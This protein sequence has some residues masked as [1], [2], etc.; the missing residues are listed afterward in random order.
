MRRRAPAAL[1]FLCLPALGAGI[2]APDQPEGASGWREKPAVEFRLH[3]A[4]TADNRASAAALEIL[5]AG[6]SALD[7][8][9]AAQMALNVVEPQ[10][11]GI[12]GGGFLLHFDAAAGRLS[13][14]DGREVA[15]RTAGVGR[16]LR[17]G[18]PLPF[19]EASLGGNAVGV[20]GLVAMLEAAHREHG[21][22]AWARLFAPAIRLAEE[23][24]AVSPRLA[25]LLAA[26]SHLRD[27]PGGRGLYYAEDGRP[28]AAGTWLRNPA[29]ADALRQVAGEGAQ[30]IATG[31]LG[32][33]FVSAVRANPRGAGDLAA[34][35]LAAYRPVARE[36]LC[37][38][39]RGYRVCGMPPPSSG[40]LGVLQI[41]GILERVPFRAAPPG[42][43]AAVHWFAEAGRL[44]YA[45]RGRYVG[46]PAFVPVP[47]RE[48]LEPGYLDGRAALL[49]PERSLGRAEPGE[50]PLLSAAAESG[51]R[52]A[53][54]HLSVVDGQ[55]NAVALTSSIEDSFGSRILAAGTLLNNQL[56]DFAFDPG[57]G[58]LS[59]A[60]RVQAGKRPMSS[61]APTMVFD[62]EGRLLAVLGSPGG[63]NIINYVA[64]AL[65]AL[66]DWRMPP[67]AV[68]A[69]P[70]FGSRNGPTLLET[71][72]PESL[73]RE[74]ES[75]G[76]EVRR[77]D[78]TSGIH[79]ILRTA[80][81]WSGAADPRR[82]GEVS[83]D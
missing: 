51:E 77:G 44:T 3:G 78:M 55:G 28:R 46:D 61:M 80:T 35:D 69:M 27:A 5:R 13:A 32:K 59:A 7:A 10:S 1:L 53:T 15:P 11:S 79:L 17:D 18:R 12:G 72:A 65:V 60:N 62:R 43:A 40:G 2:A 9:I 38:G 26:D 16:F 25:V 76:H 34:E 22:L 8:A 70:N 41:L 31:E 19:R 42:S 52:P 57:A 24:F 68:L 63:A 54:T 66:I 21:R 74:L 64:R 82:E 56:T 73:Q 48:L 75:R 58:G 37:G 50:L 81:G 39:Y 14:Y 36:P 23:G 49:R 47:V 20:P 29:L 4:A 45:D 30:A 6:G 33:A 67:A 71:S 83:G